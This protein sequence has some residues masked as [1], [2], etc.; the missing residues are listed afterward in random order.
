MSLCLCPDCGGKGYFR[1]EVPYIDP[2]FGKL[3]R[4]SNRV[5]TPEFN[6]RLAERAGLVPE[7][8]AIRLDD[9]REIHRFEPNGKE[10]PILISN[11]AML[12]MARAFVR[13]PYGFV[14]IWGGPGNAKTDVLIAMVNEVNARAGAALAVYIKFSKLAEYM[15]EAYVEYRRRKD[16]PDL[17]ASYFERFEQ[18]KAVQ[19]LAIDEFDFDGEKVR[20]TDFVKEFRF[21]F[22]DERYHL[23]T[24]ERTS[25]IF[26]SN[27]PP[28]LLPEPIF[29]RM[30]D[31]RFQIVHN[32]APSSRPTMRRPPGPTSGAG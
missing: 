10:D 31:G 24:R 6:R 15:R 30:R 20:E 18:V 11:Q 9:F 17:T 25:T 14:Y 29:D 4:C 5:H 1:L 26:A 32:N 27:N 8:L 16:N 28:D 19:V 21:D 23:A 2:R 22:L 7:D 12:E 13:E 3:V